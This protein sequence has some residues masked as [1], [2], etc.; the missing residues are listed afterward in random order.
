MKNPF[1]VLLVGLVFMA[2]CGGGSSSSSS[3]VTGPAPTSITLT[4]TTTQQIDEG[5]SV[6]INAQVVPA[7]ANQAVSW[8]L[9]GPGT[10]SNQNPTNVTY[11]APSSGAAGSS[12]VT[13]TDS[14]ATS[15]TAS[16]EIDFT[17]LPTIT[18]TSLAATTEGAPY[19]QTIAVSGGTGTITLSLAGGTSLPPGLTMDSTGHI[20]GNATGPG[21]TTNFTVIASDSSMAGQQTATKSLSITVNLPSAPTI[22]PTTLPGGYVGTPYNQTLTVNGGLGPNYNWSVNTGTLPAGLTLTGNGSTA[23]IIGIPTT[24][25]SNLAFAIQVTD[26]SSPPQQFQGSA[27]GTA[28]LDQLAGGKYV[29]DGVRWLTDA[30]RAQL[31]TGDDAVGF[32]T[33][34]YLNTAAVGAEVAAQMVASRRHGLVINE[35]DDLPLFDPKLGDAYFFSEYLGLYN[36]TDTTIYLDSLIVG[37]GLDYQ[38]DYP[39][40][41]CSASAAYQNDPL[42]VW[43]YVFH[44]LPG[45]GTDYPLPPGKSVVVAVDA[46]DHR[47]LFSLGLD[48][49]A[50]DFELYDQSGADVDNP[51]VPNAVSVGMG[52][53]PLGHGLVW[54]GLGGVVWIARP[55]DVTALHTDV[56]VG[57]TWARIPASALLDV[58][59]DKTTYDGGYRPCDWL[60]NPS[61][62]REPIRALGAGLWDDTLAYRRREVPFTINGQ[63]VL[64]Y[65]RTSAWDFGIVPLEAQSFGRP[66]IAFGRGG[67]LESVT[68]L[69]AGGHPAAARGAAQRRFGARGSGGWGA[70]EPP[71]PPIQVPHF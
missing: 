56:I 33:R 9:G 40:F 3:T 29:V 65:T 12:T 58:A 57:R 50:S 14:N 66:V 4:P 52:H 67:A 55:F 17:P 48:M 30:E 51:A 63:A 36:N 71:P 70:D 13:A 46:I 42:G 18:T 25:Q 38:Y 23:T 41:P 45:G 53:Q 37:G 16:I 62:D 44:Q 20:T 6:N 5:Q 1:L 28:T 10:L 8:T 24:I 69:D 68:G 21:G 7:T 31:P 32:V 35:W 39:I 60:V 22:S 2:G 11:T 64:Q 26:S 15:I 27:A 49:R 19:D 43:A 59:A 61:F 47:P 54:S 34:V